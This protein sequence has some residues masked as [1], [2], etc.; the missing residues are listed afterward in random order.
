MDR[1]I[2]IKSLDALMAPKSI[3]VI[4]ASSNPNRI[5][6][7]PIRHLLTAK[8][9]GDIYPVNPK[10]DEIQG[11]AA[12]PDLNSI[13]EHV[14]MAIIA[15]PA[16]VVKQVM[17]NVV[18]KGIKAVVLLAAGFAEVGDDGAAAQDEIAQIAREAG[19]RMIGPN[20]IGVVNCTRRMVA[21]FHPSFSEGIKPGGNIAL[22]SQSGALGGLSYY[23]G[24]RQGLK[25]SLV[26]TTGN[27]A[28]VQIA[29]AIAYAA[30]DESSK[31]ILACMEGIR[32]GARFIE[33]LKMAREMG[34]PIV[35]IK[36]GRTEAGAHAAQS[37]TGALAGDDAIFQ[38]IFK[39][40]GVYRAYSMEEMFSV[41][42]ACAISPRPPSNKTVIVTG[43]GGVGIMLADDGV[44]RGLAIDPLPTAFQDRI[45][46][47][48]PNAGVTNPVDVTGQVINQPELFRQVLDVIIDSPD[49]HCL[50]MHVGITPLLPG[51][52]K[53]TRENVEYIRSRRPDMAI[54]L[55]GYFPGKLKEQIEQQ[56]VFMVHEPT[57]ATRALGAVTGFAN[58]FSREATAP[59]PLQLAVKLP[60]Q[61]GE[62]EALQIM[63]S[64]GVPVVPMRVVKTPEE[65]AEAAEKLGFPVVLKLHSKQ[66]GH[67]TE[68]GGVRLNLRDASE[69]KQAFAEIMASLSKH[70][71]D[72]A[73][74]GCLVA[75]MV[76]NGVET[77]VGITQNATFGPMIM[78]GLGG[79]FAEALKDVTFRVGAISEDEAES[80]IREINGFPLLEAFRG[81]PAADIRSLALTI[82][83]V[84]MFG[85][86]MAGKVS[87]L[88]INPLI[89][90]AE[91]QGV[92]AADALISTVSGTGMDEVG[93]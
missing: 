62:Y 25:F 57:H 35:A 51:M 64:V 2:D 45:K 82:S 12:Y 3:A 14:D 21:S 11:L 65:A 4:G 6:G 69:I 15:V 92:L 13:S 77:I 67:K 80:M 75:P 47:I 89:V 28:D 61:L 55:I 88:D 17:R 85:K 38:G 86:A 60:N 29:D 93:T 18:Q 74:E 73:W 19:I 44:S 63:E 8:Y 56:G 39:Q 76:K 52:E 87:E 16:G 72:V 37:H 68:V 50:A 9:A 48:Q 58:Y 40:Y 90:K 81:R 36:V 7:L 84:S 54:G 66:V 59:E 24:H 5:G 83:R 71:P 26:A 43:S 30:N 70:R 46:T 1:N 79:V 10:R 20:C 49:I 34:K 33:A 78:F 42:A 23:E 41:G 27:E 53:H 31:V 32:D 22:V 91:G